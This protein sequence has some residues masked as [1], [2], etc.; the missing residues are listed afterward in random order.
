MPGGTCDCPV[1]TVVGEKD[2]IEK[3]DMWCPQLNPVY[4]FFVLKTLAGLTFEADIRTTLELSDTTKPPVINTM[5]S[6]FVSLDTVLF[7]FHV[8]IRS[9]RGDKTILNILKYNNIIV[10]ILHALSKDGWKRKMKLVAE[11]FLTI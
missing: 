7:I 5:H 2:K 1:V 6:K 11:S 4:H 10:V 8:G 9:L 3:I